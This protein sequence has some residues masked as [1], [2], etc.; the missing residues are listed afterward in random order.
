M[1]QNSTR[2]LATL[3]I[4]LCTYS[5]FAQYENVEIKS[6][7]LSENIYMLTG[8]GGNIVVLKGEDGVF[9]ID[10]QFA[11]LS[12]KI[13]VEVE[14]IAESDIKFLINTHWH[15]DHTGGNENFAQMGA[16]IIAHENVRERLS[17]DQIMKAFSRTV[18]ASPKAAWPV[19][20]FSEDLELY[21]NEENIMIFH[22]HNAHTDGD[23]V[24]YFPNSNII[25]TGD[26]YFSGR[27]PFIDLGSGGSVEGVIKAV[28][29]IL[30]L[31]DDDTKIIPGHGKLSNKKE[32]TA[33][34]DMLMTLRGRMKQAIKAGMTFEEIKAA[35]LSKEY[36]ESWGGGFINPEKMIN[37][38]Y[39]DLSK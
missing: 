30:F 37:T 15:G 7:Q 31:V 29:Q 13:K 8:A 12:E 33:Y 16:T 25:H 35:N 2:L 9:M 18:P 26:S 21:L 28:N 1:N 17:T 27:Y 4:T 38:L 20:T 39:T 19:I 14:R 34:R 24:V 23:A 5:L 32:L 10:G 22:V 6:H 36:D 11:P 3:L